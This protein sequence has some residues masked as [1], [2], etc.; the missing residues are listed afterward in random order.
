MG[1][2]DEVFFLPAKIKKE[3]AKTIREKKNDF[4]NDRI[5]EEF[6]NG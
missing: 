2:F 1:L 5:G 6:S 4:F 3:L